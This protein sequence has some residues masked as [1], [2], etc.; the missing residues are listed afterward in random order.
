MA[1]L[2]DLTRTILERSREGKLAWSE[3]SDAGY[4]ATI[5]GNSIVID[6][7]RTG[8]FALR[9]TNEQG[10][11]VENATSE[12]VEAVSPTSLQEIYELARRQALQVDE[13]LMKLKRA[14]EEL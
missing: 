9:I 7:G 2:A 11:M 13:T 8:G 6:R 1:I 14:L 3:L 5:G 4:I 12:Q 10:K